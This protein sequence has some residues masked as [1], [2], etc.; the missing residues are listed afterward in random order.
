MFDHIFPE[1]FT[2]TLMKTSKQPGKIHLLK[3]IIQSCREQG[4]IEH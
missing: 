4:G 3:R 2:V 1:Y